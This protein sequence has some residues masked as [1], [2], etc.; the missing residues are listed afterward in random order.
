MRSVQKRVKPFIEDVEAARAASKAY[1]KDVNAYNAAVDRKDDTLPEHPPDDDPGIGALEGV[2]AVWTSW[3]VSCGRSSTRRRR[4]RTSP[5]RRKARTASRRSS[6]N[7]L[8]EWATPWAS[9]TKVSTASPKTGRTVSA[10]TWPASSTASP[11]PSPLPRSS[12]RPSPT[13]TSGS[14]T[15]PEPP[16]SSPRTPPRPGHRRLRRGAPWRLRGQERRPAPAQPRTRAAP[17]RQRPQTDRQRSPWELHPGHGAL[18][19]R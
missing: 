2:T 5:Q 14:A 7:S 1:P 11:T 10:S 16:A 12:P 17:G 19:G 3:R 6:G 8:A 18:H 4:P 13:G 15:P 9:G